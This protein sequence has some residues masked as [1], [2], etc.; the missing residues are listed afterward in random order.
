[1]LDAKSPERRRQIAK[2]AAAARW[3]AKKLKKGS[4]K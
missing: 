4:A 2:K 1:M 3:G